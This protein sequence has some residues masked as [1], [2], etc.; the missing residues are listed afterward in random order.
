MG[1]RY[2]RHPECPSCVHYSPKRIG[3]TCIPCGAG[4][5]FEERVDQ[6]DYSESKMLINMANMKD[7]GDD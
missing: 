7:S 5:F 1:S 2:A 6:H 3:A 4:E